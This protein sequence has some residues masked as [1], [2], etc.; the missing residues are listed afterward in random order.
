VAG[1][2]LQVRPTTGIFNIGYTP[3]AFIA[4]GLIGG[5][6]AA[7]GGGKF[8]AGFLAAAIATF[9]PQPVAGESWEQEFEGT[10][11]SAVLGGV[12]S[13]IGGGKFSN[14]ATT[15]AFAYLF[16]ALAHAKAAIL[17]PLTDNEQAAASLQ[18]PGINVDVIRIT[19]DGL[20]G[21]AY[22]PDNTI[23]FPSNF[24]FCS[25]FTSCDDGR[26]TGWFIHE[27]THVWQWQQGMDPVLGHIFSMH[28]FV[29]D[30]YLPFSQYNSSADWWAYDTE[31]QADWNKWN[32]LC[33]TNRLKNC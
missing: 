20:F 14:G 1:G 26:W 17:R 25:D 12:G 21:S 9:A 11:E 7:I 18:F 2:I 23:H 27:V 6:T 33:S 22:T 15:A 10:T 24:S 16:N 30:N 4:H 5:L 19:F 8:G 3:S 28:A 31:Q 13:V 32:F 29:N